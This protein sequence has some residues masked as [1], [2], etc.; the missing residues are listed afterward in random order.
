MTLVREKVRCFDCLRFRR[1]CKF[2]PQAVVDCNFEHPTSFCGF[3]NMDVKP[4][5]VCV[6]GVL[7]QRFDMLS[8]GLVE[9]HEHRFD[10]VLPKES[11]GASAN[12]L[13][14]CP[15]WANSNLKRCLPFHRHRERR[16]KQES[17]NYL[18]H[19][20]WAEALFF[21]SLPKLSEALW[22]RLRFPQL[23]CFTAPRLRVVGWVARQRVM[24]FF[25]NFGADSHEA[26][27]PIGKRSFKRKTL[28]KRFANF[29]SERK[30]NG[31][32]RPLAARITRWRSGIVIVRRPS[33]FLPE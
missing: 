16:R 21:L 31:K 32:R 17:Q 8:I 30:I 1:M 27:L 4:P 9:I 7:S 18:F 25:T 10:V 11:D 5:S 28:P 2:N 23:C 13:V 26:R 22:E 3:A 12:G 29:G 14:S 20:V 6:F 19:K 15:V 24:G 33:H